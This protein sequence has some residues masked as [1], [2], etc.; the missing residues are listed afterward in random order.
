MP[1]SLRLV[2]FLDEEFLALV[3]DNADYEGWASSKMIAEAILSEEITT[4]NVG[5]RLAWMK[6]YGVVERDTRPGRTYRHW[7]LTSAGEALVRARFTKR[8]TDALHTV[9]DEQLWRLT[10][11]LSDRY[12]V[13]DD[14]TANLVR[15]RFSAAAQRRRYR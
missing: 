8:Q 1:D 7:R 5:S 10:A 14:T 12:E 13:V 15:R 4:R 2:D 6:K 9:S 3:V 11:E